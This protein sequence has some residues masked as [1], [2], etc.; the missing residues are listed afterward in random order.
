MEQYNAVMQKQFAVILGSAAIVLLMSYFIIR[1]NRE[2]ARSDEE[3]LSKSSFLARMSHEMRTPLNAVIGLSEMELQNDLPKSMR[4]NLEKIYNSGSS[5]LG[6]VNDILD[7]S[8]IASGNFELVPVKYSI[9]SLLNDTVQLN[10]VRIGSKP[11]VFEL[12]V[13]ETIPSDFYGDEM[14]VKQILNNLLSNAFKYTK[15]GK[16]CLRLDWER[17]NSSAW[18]IFTVSDTGRGIRKENLGSLFSDYYQA[19]NHENR[20]VEGTGLGLPITKNL[21]ELMGGTITVE[22]E[23]EK[24]SVFSVKIRQEIVDATPVGSE[25]AENLRSFR[26]RENR[27]TRSRNLIRT[28]MP[29]GKVLIVD[30]I[31]TNLDVAKGL[32]LPYGLEIDLAAGGREA[33]EKIRE[34]KTRYDVVFMDHMMPEMDGIE[35]TRVIRGKIGTDYA[36][37][38]PIIALTA[39][40]MRGNEEMFL[41]NG[42]DAFI[43]KPIDIMQLD[44]VL[45]RWVRDRQSEKMPQQ[46]EQTTTEKS[47]ASRLLEGRRVEGVDFSAGAERY[48]GENA[49]LQILRSFMT[50]TPELLEKMRGVSEETLAGYAITVHGLKGASYGICAE[51]LARQAQVLES[52][53]K[54]GDFETV[55]AENG[56]FIKAAEAILSALRDL[57]NDIKENEDF[58]K[59]SRDAPDEALLAKLRDAA[60][61]FK[62]TAMDEIVT[63]LE[64]YRYESDGELVVWLREQLDELEY[65]KIQKRLEEVLEK[66]EKNE[67]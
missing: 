11:V 57:L 46:A 31:P 29:Y 51:A 4:A 17:H 15:K 36:R 13:D 40:A 41:A 5:L 52:A 8:K 20:Y 50:H 3:N 49:Y 24:G 48:E 58:G 60:E 43:S 66:N 28:R 9:A 37:T 26:F 62:F 54:A 44:M 10:I 65:E 7:I 53:A 34:E 33:I 42:F 47:A 16:V 35:T 21:A 56:V 61:H 25:T 59:E 6:I 38:V 45:N 1:L 67:D 63:E 64:R 22:S 30:D 19:D 2:K 32:M 14:R 27:S 18:L 12:S 55:R 39:N 23:Y